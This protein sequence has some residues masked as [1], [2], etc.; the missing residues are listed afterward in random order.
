MLISVLTVSRVRRKMLEQKF[1]W[2]QWARW[3]SFFKK[4]GKHFRESIMSLMGRGRKK[5][6][7]KIKGKR[8]RGQRE[9]KEHDPKVEREEG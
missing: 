1:R 8:G 3:T 6:K 9:K 5:A 2:P 7:G 4:Q